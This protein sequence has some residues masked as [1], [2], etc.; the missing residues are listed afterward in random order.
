MSDTRI[1]N[2]THSMVWM[3][4]FLGLSSI[5]PLILRSVIIRYMGIEYAGL[6][7]LFNSVMQI[8]NISELGLGEAIVFYLY[9]PM[10]ERDEQRI[11]AL[12]NLYRKVY[13]VIGLIFAFVSIIMI[14]FLPLLV[15]GDCPDDINMLVLYLIY[16]GN[17]V[18]AYFYKSYVVSIFQ[19][20]QALYYDYMVRTFVWIFAYTIQFCAVMIYRNYYIFAVA[21][22][23]VTLSLNTLDYLIVRKKY[24]NYF[25]AGKIEKSFFPDFIKKVSAMSFMK[26]RNM[27]RL[28]LDTVV[29]SSFVGLV[30]LAK[31]NNYYMIMAL[32]LML[33]SYFRQAVLQ[34][35]GN[36]VAMESKE[37]N[38]G[39]VKLYSFCLQWIN[40]VF[41]AVLLCSYHDFI[42][43]W[44]G[45]ES[46]FGLKI[47][48]LFV[49]YYYVRQMTDISELIRN[50]TG[51]WWQGKWVP[52]AETIT[53]L[54]LNIVFANIWGIEG[55]LWAT[56]ISIVVVNIPFETYYVFNKYFNDKTGRIL[57]DYLINGLLAILII[58]VSYILSSKI[59]VGGLILQFILKAMVATVIS[60]ILFMILHIKDG[61]MKDI[62]EIFM[63]MISRKES[64]GKQ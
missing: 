44:V 50:S 36:S 24:P 34:S 7:S 39:V 41:S 53:N 16:V 59:I 61:R 55:V 23:F 17:T 20:N 12:L 19:T 38:R 21:N 8:F 56:I 58:G 42:T 57:A 25:P 5:A 48:I 43:L 18:L 11:N 4:I 63:R 15:K 6:N 31:Y 64:S 14:P 62:I 2:V 10:A 49:V 29:I 22:I 9:K 28:S 37:S 30:A 46:V 54:V 13:M 35:L 26:I 33:S 51:I 45:E 60:A 32:P 1:K 40:V 27:L 47:E 3:M 52:L